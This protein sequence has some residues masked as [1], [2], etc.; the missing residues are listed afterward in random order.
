[1]SYLIVMKF[2]FAIDTASGF[3]YD[4]KSVDPEILRRE[5]RKRKVIVESFVR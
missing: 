2:F 5:M 4:G 3:L 1:M